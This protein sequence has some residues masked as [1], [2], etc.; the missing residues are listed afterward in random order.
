MEGLIGNERSESSSAPDLPF[1]SITK[2]D[3]RQE[4]FDPAK[5]TVALLKAG[6]ASGDFSDDTARLLTIRV[7]SLAQALSHSETPSVEEIQDIVEEPAQPLTLADYGP[8]I[9]LLYLGLFLHSNCQG[10]CEHADRSQRSLELVGDAGYE[11]G[12]HLC[13][14]QVS[15]H[16]APE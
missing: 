2:R 14:R 4:P 1:V 8:Q 9:I 3:G 7:L 16:I 13:K 15:V 6:R 5:I 12:P 11:L 10:F